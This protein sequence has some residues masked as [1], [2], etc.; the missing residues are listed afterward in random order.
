MGE[1]EL[2]DLLIEW[3][4]NKAEI[5]VRKHGI[6]FEDA[7]RIFLDDNRI[8]FLDEKHSDDEERWKVI[9]MVKNILAVI[10]TERGEKLRL[11]SARYA[12]REE[13]DEYYGQYP[14]L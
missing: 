14:Y 8:D 9:G 5:N 11:I 13:E 4:D 7:A 1:L 3:D 12:N 6:H 10:Y 2:E